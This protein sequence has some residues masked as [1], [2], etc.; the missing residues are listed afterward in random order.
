MRAILIAILIAQIGLA[1]KPAP[2]PD[3][4]LTTPDGRAVKSAQLNIPN[5]W[6][7]IYVQPN[8]GFSESILNELK[9]PQQ[10]SANQKMVVIIGGAKPADAKAMVDQFPHMQSV[11]WYADPKHEARRAMQIGG[12]PCVLGMNNNVVQWQFI[13]LHPKPGHLHSIL[14]TWRDKK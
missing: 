3:F 12:V 13:G 7:L 11:T 9:D 1:K 5:Q 6:L 8:S 10:A 2:L 4:N 14:K